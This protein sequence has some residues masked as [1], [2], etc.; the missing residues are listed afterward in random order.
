MEW[1]ADWRG[2]FESSEGHNLG[3]RHMIKVGLE[4]DHPNPE[5]SRLRLM[6]ELYKGLDPHGQFYNNSRILWLWGVSGIL[7]KFAEE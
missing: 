6:A 7:M 2:G 4:F 3:H 5:Q 1:Q